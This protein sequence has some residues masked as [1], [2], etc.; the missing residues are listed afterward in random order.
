MN[1]AEI[2]KHPAF[3]RSPVVN[4]RR[5][6]PTPRDIPMLNRERRHREL[7]AQQ[8]AQRTPSPEERIAEYEAAFQEAARGLLVAAR[9]LSAVKEK[10]RS[11]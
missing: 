10:L 11:S 5:R 3:D 8:E 2:L 4:A 7:K 6:G 9:A 1:D